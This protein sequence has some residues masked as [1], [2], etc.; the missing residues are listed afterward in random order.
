MEV[1]LQGSPS[2]QEPVGG[3]KLPNNLRELH[4]QETKSKFEFKEWGV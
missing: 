3:T 2:Q 1:V 4:V